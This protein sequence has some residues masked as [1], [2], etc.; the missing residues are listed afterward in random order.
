MTYEGSL[1][2]ESKIPPGK[3]RPAK[4]GD[5]KRAGR[6][7][8]WRDFGRNPKGRGRFCA[9][10]RQSLLMYFKYTSSLL[11]CAA[12]KRPPPQRSFICQQTLVRRFIKIDKLST[13]YGTDEADARPYRFGYGVLDENL[14]SAR[15]A[16]EKKVFF[17]ISDYG[18]NYVFF[19]APR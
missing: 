12:Q 9:S 15:D 8:A 3:A 13:A 17:E 6:N 1:R 4:L 16:D 14:N 10:L 2:C 7:A 11:P 18:T 19:E 5:S